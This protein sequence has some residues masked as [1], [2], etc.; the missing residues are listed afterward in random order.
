MSF[1]LTKEPISE[2]N[3]RIGG[4]LQGDASSLR[5]QLAKEQIR[6]R[7]NP[8]SAPHFGGS[9]E[10]EVRSVKTALRTTLGAQIV[11]E[12]VLRTIL[13]EVEGILNSRLL[14]Y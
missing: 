8:L 2:G 13:V 14:C 10:R 11:T 4:S 12:E 1:C 9:W 3:Y 5:H 7:F 6:L